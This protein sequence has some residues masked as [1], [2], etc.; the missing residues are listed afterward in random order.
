VPKSRSRS[1]NSHLKTSEAKATLEINRDMAVTPRTCPC[2]GQSIYPKLMDYLP[3]PG[4]YKQYRCPKCSSWL[5]IDIKSR[6]KLIALGSVGILGIATGSALLLV[7]T[8]AQI[9]GHERL[10]LL[11]FAIVFGFLLNHALA[12]YVRSVAAWKAVDD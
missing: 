8:R 10:A 7:Y 11:P 6:I 12:R 2:C 4:T 1:T 5:T 9:Q 3:R